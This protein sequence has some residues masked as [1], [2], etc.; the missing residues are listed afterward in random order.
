MSENSPLISVVI[1]AYNSGRTIWK[2]LGSI[3]NQTY[4]NIEIIVVDALN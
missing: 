2:C 4:S 3:K 1:A